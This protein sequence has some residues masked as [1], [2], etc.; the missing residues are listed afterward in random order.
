LTPALIAELRAALSARRRMVLA[1]RLSDGAQRLTEPGRD[2][3]SGITLI[4]GEEWFLHEFA[5]PLRLLVVGATHLAQTLAQH[6]QLLDFVVSIIDPRAMF[7]TAERFPRCELVLSWPGA[8][9]EM[10]A[11]DRDSA[12][13]VLSHEAKFDDPALIAALRSPAF[14][15]GAL[16]SRKTQAARRGRLAAAGFGAAEQGRIHGP[17]GLAIGAIGAEE[18][19]VAI[20]AEIIAVRRGAAVQDRLPAEDRRAGTISARVE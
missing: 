12:I 2:T 3:P 15:I 8:A 1:T 7:A 11:P 17:V 16:G 18:I 4:D 6:A 20:L 13:V 9:L 14:Y 5:P 19:A 10:L